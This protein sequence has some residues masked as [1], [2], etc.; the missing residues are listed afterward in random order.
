[1]RIFGVEL[2]AASTPI[3]MKLKEAYREGLFDEFISSPD[4]DD[5]DE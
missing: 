5:D 3:G 1:M 4:D 2:D